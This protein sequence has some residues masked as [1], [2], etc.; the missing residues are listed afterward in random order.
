M[1]RMR[2]MRIPLPCAPLQS[3]ALAVESTNR[4]M[5]CVYV[6]GLETADGLL[7]SLAKL[8]FFQPAH[9][10]GATRR[11]PAPVPPCPPAAAATVGVPRLTPSGEAED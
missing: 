7:R 8:K 2:R 10:T 3:A 5:R 4:M 6:F 9:P 11:H 1:R